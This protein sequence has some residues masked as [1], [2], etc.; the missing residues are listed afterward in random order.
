MV[1]EEI[2]YNPVE[3]FLKENLFCFKTTQKAGSRHLGFADVVGIRDTGGKNSPEFELIGVEIKRDTS[4]IGKKLGQTLGY[5]L[6]THRCYLA[7]PTK[8][9]TKHIEFANRLG[10]GLIEISHKEDI[11]CYE[12][13]TA[14]R[15]EPY[16]S[17][18]YRLMEKSLKLSCCDYCG[19]VFS[20]ENKSWTRNI[21]DCEGKALYIRHKLPDRFNVISGEML[22]YKDKAICD[23]CLKLFRI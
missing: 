22:N 23:E 15:H 9:D 11:K 20:L 3:Q 6:F 13:L 16:E 7:V 5:S 17:L 2:Y 14:Q 21:K 8:F 18:V 1:K 4:S 10:V 12:I 19:I